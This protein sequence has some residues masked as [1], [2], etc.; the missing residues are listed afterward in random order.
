[1]LKL[2]WFA[3]GRGEG[4]RGLLR[5]AMEAIER[6]ELDGRILFVFCNRDPGEHEGSDQF[7]ALA[8]GYNLPLVTFSSLRFRRQRSARSIAEVRL[9]YDCEVMRRL[10]GFAPDLCVLAGYMLIVGREMCRRYAMLNLHPALPGGPVGTWQEVIWKLIESRAAETGA[11]VHLVT[12]EVDQG[13][14][15]AYFKFPIQGGEF[16]P[17]W[18]EVAGRSA[19]GLKASVGEALPLFQ[20]IR[21]EGMRR[22]RPLLLETLKAFAAGRVKAVG[23][24][25][26]DVSGAPVA[27]VCLNA[28]VDAA[29]ARGAG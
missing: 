11:M 12:E 16:A 13:P 6:G 15:I 19:E 9:E 4:S 25:V 21:Q 3:T 18:A 23:G 27:G 24:Q 29:L 5:M 26:V 8:R 20:R 1:M 2:G 7:I 14:P 17:L 22:E 10:E 28:E